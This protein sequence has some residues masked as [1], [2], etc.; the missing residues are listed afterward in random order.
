VSN[1]TVADV[2]HCMY[3][4]NTTYGYLTTKPEKENWRE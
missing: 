1:D 4:K 2:D 3:Y